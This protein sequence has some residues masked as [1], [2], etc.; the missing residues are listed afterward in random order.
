M[1][2][3]NKSIEAL[4]EMCDLP[5]PDRDV[6]LLKKVIKK[7]P[8]KGG[9]SELAKDLIERTKTVL[10]LRGTGATS[11]GDSAFYSYICIPA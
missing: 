1:T 3:N 6:E 5:I 11:I 8:I 10:D 4:K 7:L 2:D 9:S